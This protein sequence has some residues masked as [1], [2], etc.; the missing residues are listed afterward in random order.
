MSMYEYDAEIGHGEWVVHEPESRDE[1]YKATITT[2]WQAQGIE[3]LQEW[4][5]EAKHLSI[6]HS[7]AASLF[8]TLFRITGC[9]NIV[10]SA[11]AAMLSLSSS[12]NSNTQLSLLTFLSTSTVILTGTQNY[13]SWQVRREIHTI[14]S[15][16]YGNLSKKIDCHLHVPVHQ[17]ADLKVLF[18]KLNATFREL[19]LRAPVLP[20]WMVRFTPAL[21]QTN[22]D[23]P[24]AIEMT[25]I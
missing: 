20:R 23:H 2:C 19:S 25:R 21:K 16:E 18:Q 15:A 1:P 4:M 12:N 24:P 14:M 9:C 5:Q 11:G 6:Y 13:F 7:K 17:R 8:N 3:K 22:T 10:F